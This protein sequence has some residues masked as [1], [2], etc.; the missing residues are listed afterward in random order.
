[1]AHERYRQT[2]DR[3]TDDD[4]SEFTFAKNQRAWTIRKRRPKEC[5][6]RLVGIVTGNDWLTCV[7]VFFSKTSSKFFVK[8]S[9]FVKEAQGKYKIW[10]PDIWILRGRGKWHLN[11]SQKGLRGHK[12][13]PV[14]VFHNV[15]KPAEFYPEG[16]RGDGVALPTKLKTFLF[17]GLTFLL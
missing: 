15:P 4:M 10:G 1:M 17:Y 8:F 7:L 6:D 14:L 2:D 12:L 5:A 11:L 16:F 9:H 3:R 13:F